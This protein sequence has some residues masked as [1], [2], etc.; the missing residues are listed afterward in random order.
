[1]GFL[2]LENIEKMKILL[3]VIFLKGE[4]GEYKVK[5]L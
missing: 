3:F 2:A 1:M 4:R 5:V